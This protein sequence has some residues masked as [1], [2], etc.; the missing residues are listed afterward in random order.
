MKETPLSISGADT[1]F[2]FSLYGKDVFTPVAERLIATLDGP[3]GVSVITVYEFENAVRFAV[4]R[5][6]IAAEQ[7]AGMRDDF[8]ADMNAGRVTE[9]PLNLAAVFAEARRLSRLKTEG[10]G[11]RSYD[12][13]HVAAARIVKSERFLSFD[14]NQRKLARFAGLKILP[15]RSVAMR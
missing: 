15:S 11:H 12:I 1:S 6:S 7:G 8:A 13:L 2:L 14:E 9:I 4:F 5:K 3:V 10:G